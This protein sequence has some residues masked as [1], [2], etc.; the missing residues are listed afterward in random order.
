MIMRAALTGV[1]LLLA[2]CGL[3]PIYADGRQ[4]V[5]AQSLA[6]VTVGPIPERSGQLLREELLRRMQPGGNP[7]YRL[8]VALKEKIEGFGIRGDESV[9]RERVSLIAT[10]RLIDLA[11]DQVVLEEIA[12]SDAGIDVVRS[13][14]A[15]VAA[16]Q[17]ATERNT[18]AV[19]ER[20]VNRLALHFRTKP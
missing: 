14:F 10:Y 13:E 2:G 19:A 12:S 17:T 7:T 11:T 6:T 18:L 3:Q 15:V 1:L 20:I 9:A 16:E 4:G 8:D 5:A